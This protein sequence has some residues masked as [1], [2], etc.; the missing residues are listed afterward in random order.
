MTTSLAN[1]GV[2]LNKSIKKSIAVILL[3]VMVISI[4]PLAFAERGDERGR[5]D[6]RVNSRMAIRASA[7]ADDDT[8]KNGDREDDDDNSVDV[9]VEDETRL[10]ARG[11]G[12]SQE[13]SRSEK[14]IIKSPM[15]PP[16][17]WRKEYFHNQMKENH[18][19]LREVYDQ[20]A[21][22]CTTGDQD[23]QH[24]CQTSLQDKYQELREQ[25]MQKM[26]VYQQDFVNTLP[27]W[28]ESGQ[29]GLW[30]PHEMMPPEVMEK[31]ME[32]DVFAE[33]LTGSTDAETRVRIRKQIKGQMKATLPASDEAFEKARNELE[34]ARKNY[35]LARKHY[36]EAQQRFA[37]QKGRLQE[38][39][40]DFRVCEQ[41]NKK[42]E[43]E[44]NKCGETRKEF[45]KE[46]KEFLLK[47]AE[48]VHE[49]VN[50]VKQRISM[51][52]ELTAEE[53]QKML[54]MFEQRMKDVDNAVVVV[55]SLDEPTPREEYRKAAKIIKETLQG[56]RFMLKQNVGVLAEAKLGNIISH[57]A[58][59]KEQFEAK[60]DKLA[61]DGKDTA[62]LD[63]SLKEFDSNVKLAQD[64]YLDAQV[65]FKQAK[66]KQSPELVKEAHELLKKSRYYVKEARNTLRSIVK[67]LKN[68]G[69]MPSVIVPI[70]VPS[71]SAPQDVI[72]EDAE[73]T[74]TGASAT[75]T[76]ETESET[77][78]AA[79]S[80]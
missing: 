26:E 62:S 33:D 24:T 27:S 17:Q 69:G 79:T 68:Q 58:K 53:K 72:V 45:N 11:R 25:M 10:R 4:V 34:E 73:E 39:R 22:Q 74:E 51:S 80:G 13:R 31:I 21:A 46:S 57:L 3:V 76:S 44:S 18:D 66:E 38:L 60:R 56:I 50:K 23:C 61:E 29:E 54:E 30:M 9:A 15:M 32:G 78:V 59:L 75:V 12:R 55:K 70:P 16:G 43:T 36:E 71:G 41:Q 77:E 65:K 35:Q 42:G 52:E 5:S 40:D 37:Q 28:Q 7:S 63:K 6:V 64:L 19:E 2:G 47:T 20:C 8:D 67:E 48:L 1:F 49:A 14:S